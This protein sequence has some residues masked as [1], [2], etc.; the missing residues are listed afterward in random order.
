MTPSQSLKA[1]EADGHVD[2]RDTQGLGQKSSFPYE[3]FLKLFL[4][5]SV[6]LSVTTKQVDH[7]SRNSCSCYLVEEEKGNYLLISSS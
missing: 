4:L 3:S 5:Q 6:L 7:V 1:T 2:D